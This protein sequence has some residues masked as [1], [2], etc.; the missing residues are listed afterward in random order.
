MGNGDQAIAVGL[1]QMAMAY[2]K[3]SGDR[4]TS[5]ALQRAIDVA[6]D[7]RP[8]LPGE[9]MDPETACLVAGIRLSSQ[10]DVLPIEGRE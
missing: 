1:M 7:V 6:H 10:P 9:A 4:I 8:L 2:L 3:K 5:T